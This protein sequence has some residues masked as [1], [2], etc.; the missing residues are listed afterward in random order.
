MLVRSPMFFPTF[1]FYCII[2]CIE[3]DTLCAFSCLLSATKFYFRHTLYIQCQFSELFVSFSNIKP[4]VFRETSKLKMSSNCHLYIPPLFLLLLLAINY[5]LYTI[6][7]LSILSS[8]TKRLLIYVVCF[9]ILFIMLVWS[10]LSAMYAP[11]ALVPDF[12]HLNQEES[13]LYNETAEMHKAYTLQTIM[14]I[15]QLELHTRTAHGVA[16]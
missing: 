5:F 4:N 12:F 15:K 6:P 10:F 16:R 14:D 8:D 3:L 7:L 11:P 2:V 13:N 9:N 1:S